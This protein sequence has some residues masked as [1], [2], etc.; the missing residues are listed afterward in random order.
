VVVAVLAMACS[1]L[2]A[3]GPAALA[4]E[5]VR[6]RLLVPPRLDAAPGER[7]TVVWALAGPDEHGRRRPFNAIGVFVRLL[8]AT[9]GRPTIGF[10]TPD[11]HPQGRY[12]ARVAVPQGGVGGL[13]IGLRGSSDVLFPLDHHPFA[14]PAGEPAT[15]REAPPGSP[16]P[17]RLALA[18]GVALLV[19]LAAARRRTRRAAGQEPAQAA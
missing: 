6:A 5:D 1:L 7:L 11:E 19:T 14:A 13:Q 3:G 18:A 10:A 17:T 2:A 4:K 12:D 15:G 9:G 16:W 8:S